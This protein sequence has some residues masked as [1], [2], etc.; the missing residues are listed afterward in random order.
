MKADLD[1]YAPAA[2]GGIL[3]FGGINLSRAESALL[4]RQLGAIQTHRPNVRLLSEGDMLDRPR[5]IRSGWACRVRFLSDGRRQILNYYL[6]GDILGLS[7]DPDPVAL[8][9]YASL[10]RLMTMEVGTLRT[11]ALDRPDEYPELAA[12]C[13]RMKVHEEFYLLAQITRIGRQKAY[14]RVAHLLLEFYSRLSRTGL[15]EGASFQ[16]PLTQEALADGLGLSAVHVNRTFK[17][18]KRKNYVRVERGTVTLLEREALAEM[19]GFREPED[20]FQVD[21][22]PHKTAV[23]F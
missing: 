8:A 11:L 7:L 19:C 20:L 4:A 18:L 17:L 15:A 1:R 6:P 22:V 3:T 14:E 21:T 10:T 9:G 2:F 23:S 16:L 13:R 12:A 5:L